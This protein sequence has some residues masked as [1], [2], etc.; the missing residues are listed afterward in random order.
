MAG[1]LKS[2][3]SNVIRL[4]VVMT[5]QFILVPITLHALGAE[6]YGVYSLALSVLGFFGLLELGA[7]T[8]AVKYAAAARGNQDL[9]GRNRA[10]STLLVMS[11]GSCAL[12]AALMIGLGIAF[13][14]MF[15]HK[16][17]NQEAILAFFILG[18]RGAVLALP[19]GVYRSSLIGDNRIAVANYVQIFTNI[20]LALTT[21]I[22][23]K[24][25]WGLIGVSSS[26]LLWFGVEAGSYVV[27]CRK[28]IQDFRLNLASF[29]KALLKQV[30]SLSISQLFVTVS[31]MILLRTDPIIVGSFLSIKAVGQYGVALRISESVFQLAKQYVNA[32][33]PSIARLHGAKDHTG[34]QKLYIKSSRHSAIVAGALIVAVVPW[35]DRLL[36]GWVKGAWPEEEMLNAANVMAIL[37]LA[38]AMTTLQMVVSNFLT[39]TDRHLLTVRFSVIGMFINVGASLILVHVMG[40][41]GV[42]TGTL[43]SVTI[44]DV[45]YATWLGSQQL[46]LSLVRFWLDGPVRPVVGAIFVSLAAWQAKPYLAT[47]NLATAALASIITI[48][49]FGCFYFGVLSAAED[50]EK[51][52]WLLKKGSSKLSRR[53]AS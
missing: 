15:P 36:I 29:D 4:V 25:G 19:A 11:L 17:I 20:G 47:H 26:A 51:I 48:G 46:G 41:T 2:T 43:V 37:S 49:L 5:C 35:S 9:L 8:A 14:Y 1:V 28:M 33:S 6:K 30:A 7:G 53:F 38:M 31:G 10:I 44:V 16:G 52:T 32:L 39:F 50:R 22:F 42:A 40:L 27:L 45:A 23:L 21:W 3:A 34:L 18:A 24:L 13:P 12:G